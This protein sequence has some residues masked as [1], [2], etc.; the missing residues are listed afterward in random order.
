MWNVIVPAH[1]KFNSHTHAYSIDSE[2]TIYFIV[3]KCMGIQTNS[4]VYYEAVL[5]SKG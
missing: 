4:S 3:V 5:V 1:K 2:K